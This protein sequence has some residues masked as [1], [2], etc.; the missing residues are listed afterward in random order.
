MSETALSDS[1]ALALAGTTDS[2]TDFAYHTVGQ[3][4]YYLDGFRQRHRLL[5]VLKPIN[6]LRVYQDG[7]LTFGVRAGKY[8]NGDAAVD[9]AGAA[10]QALTNNATNY[11]YLTAGGTLAVNTTG[12]P[13]PSL[14]PHIPLAT[15]VTAAGQYA[16][17]D[18]TDYR[19]RAMFRVI[20]AGGGF[21]MV[22]NGTGSQIDAGELLHVTG[23][24]ATNAALEVELADADTSGRPAHLVADAN[25]ANGATGEAVDIY[26]LAGQNTSAASVGDPVYLSATEGGW[27]LTPPAGADQIRQVVGFV[28]VSHAS[29]GEILFRTDLLQ[30]AEKLGTSGLQDNSVATAKIAAD[31]VTGPKI[32]PAFTIAMHTPGDMAIDGDS[33]ASNGGGL[34]G[35]VAMSDPGNAYAQVYDHG[36]TTY[37]Q[38][39]SASSLT[40]WT[41]DWQIAADAASEEIDDAAYFGASVPFA[42]IAFPSYNTAGIY[43][44]DTFTWEYYNG[45]SW[46]ALTVAQDNSDATAADGKRS[47]SQAGALHFIPPSDWATTTI[48]GQSAYWIGARVTAAAVTSTPELDD[49][50]HLIVTPADAFSLPADGQVTA[51]R[52]VDHAATLHT[53]AD[54][55]FLFMNF[56]T[57]DH[58]GELTWAQD[59]AVDAWTL[60]TPLTVTAGDDL[61][62]LVTQED[63]TNE[64]SNADF[65]L[66]YTMT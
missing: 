7:D 11:I 2:D 61:G 56:T 49:Q 18:I 32:A 37:A 4:T 8:F 19:A 50:N 57:G 21:A 58:S 64:I 5:T 46:A 22:Y 3:S 25:I 55:K 53:T 52:A 9:Y 10:A 60:G 12:F 26:T 23:Y 48:N 17:G 43:S 1:E 29:T 63:G 30:V 15:I 66:T 47:F 38:L 34:V 44:G 36:T 42:E 39:S 54:V 35:D 6:H 33:A 62:I 65:E 40:G 27:T 24:D 16:Y 51:V 28:T 13:V 20:G 45:A 14:T 59:K 31:A 41:N